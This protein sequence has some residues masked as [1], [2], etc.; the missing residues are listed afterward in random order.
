MKTTVNERC[1]NC[2]FWQPS[3]CKR[4][5]PVISGVSGDLRSSWPLVMDYD[6][7]GDWEIKNP[8]GERGSYAATAGET[9]HRT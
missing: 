1:A 4:H 9:E 3:V 2:R 6:W 5:A 7:C 8:N